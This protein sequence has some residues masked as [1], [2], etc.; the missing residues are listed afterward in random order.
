MPIVNLSLGDIT[1]NSS[2]KAGDVVYYIPANTAVGGF[3]THL[4]SA[5]MVEI[6]PIKE[7][8]TSTDMPSDSN[9]EMGWIIACYYEEGTPLPET[10]DFLFFAKNRAVNEASIVG[11]YG[12]FKFKNNSR[13]KAELFATSC[14]VNVSSK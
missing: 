3:N 10:G 6:G 1:I 2:C 13:Q 5:S 14:N 9:A 7:L 4:N 8:L 12:K 11:Y